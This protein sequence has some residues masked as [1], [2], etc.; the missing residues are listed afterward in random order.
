VSVFAWFKFVNWYQFVPIVS[1]HL[2]YLKIFGS[3]LFD[4]I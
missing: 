2:M 4:D 3:T 1:E